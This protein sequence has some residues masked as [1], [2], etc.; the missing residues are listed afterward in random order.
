MCQDAGVSITIWS[1]HSEY[2][3]RDVAGAVLLIEQ[4]IH[5]RPRGFLSGDGG[6]VAE[7]SLALPA[8]CFEVLTFGVSLMDRCGVIVIV[9]RIYDTRRKWVLL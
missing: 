5:G 9:I 7:W 6:S 8:S 2:S 1:V 3:H 4:R